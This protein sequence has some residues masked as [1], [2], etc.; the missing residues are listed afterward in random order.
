MPA[1]A[2]HF[3]VLTVAGWLSRRQLAAVEYL[4]AENAVLRAQLG[5]KRLLLTDG[6][7]R[8]LAEKGRALGRNGLAEMASI[9]TADTILRWYRELVAQKYDGST[10]RG[11]GRPRKNRD[12]RE[13][14]VRMARENPQWGYTRIVGALKNVGHEVGRTT[15]KRILAEEGIAPAPERRKGMSWKTFLRVHWDAIAAADFFSVEVLTLQG[16]THYFVFFVMELKTRRVQIAG[17]V[18]QPYGGWMMQVG[19]GLLDAVDGFLLGKKYLIV[20]RDPVYTAQFRRLLR[21]DGVELLRL[22]AKSPNLNAYAE[23]FVRSIREECLDHVVLLGEGHLRRVVGE[24]VAHY[25]RERNHQG[26][27]NVLIEAVP[28]TSRTDVIVRKQRLNGLLSF[29]EREAA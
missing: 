29:Y 28:S 17:I 15:V 5:S 24:Y 12:V 16:L 22:P 14:V 10:R 23:R 20:D 8:S 11:P 18:H 21:D 19:R 27:G 7:R 6:Q 1:T 25:H 2:L 4:R 9:A 13:L 3:L 26:I